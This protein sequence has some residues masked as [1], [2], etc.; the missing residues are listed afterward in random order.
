MALVDNIP[1]THWRF[2]EI[3]QVKL[4]VNGRCI[5]SSYI[6]G[7]GGVLL[8]SSGSWL[9]GFSANFSV[10]SSILAELLALEH[11]FS[12]AWNM[13]FRKVVMES[14][15]LEVAHII[16]KGFHTRIHRILT[17]V[18]NV[19]F[20]LARDWVVDRKFVVQEA[21]MV[22]NFM[23]KLGSHSSKEFKT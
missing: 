13:G 2:P 1:L 19:R 12:L 16:S 5:R 22:T 21:N 10:S 14:D 17:V 11:G 7:G 15:C 20:W 18:N 8:E 6:M 23:P 9:V 3:G 4:N